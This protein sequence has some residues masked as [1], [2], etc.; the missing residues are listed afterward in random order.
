MSQPLPAESPKQELEGTP[1]LVPL[2][3]LLLLA[4]GFALAFLECNVPIEAERNVA[5]LRQTLEVR[6]RRSR[7]L[8][9]NEPEEDLFGRI[10][11]Q[12]PPMATGEALFVLGFEQSIPSQVEYPPALTRLN[13]ARE[14]FRE[15]LFPLVLVLPRYA[16]DQ[17]S[18]EAPDFWAWRSGVFEA[19]I[20]QARLA[21]LL[22]DVARSDF[23]VYDSLSEPR[24]GDH[25]EALQGLL[26]ELETQGKKSER[27]RVALHRR[28][29]VILTSMLRWP[30]ARGHAE[31]VLKLAK[32]IGDEKGAATAYHLLGWIAQSTG[33]YEEASDWYQKVLQ[34]AERHGD[35]AGVAFTF[36]L[37][38]TVAQFREA[39]EEARESFLKAL[40]IFEELGRPAEVAQSYSQLGM[41]AMTLGAHMEAREW[42]LKAIQLEDKLGDRTVIASICLG[43]GAVATVQGI[44]EEAVKWGRKA[45]TIFEELG[46]RTGMAQAFSQ[47]GAAEELRGSFDEALE[48]HGKALRISEALGDR[49]AIASSASQ[50]GVLLTERGSPGEAVLWNLR[51]LA[52][53]LEHELPEIGIDLHWL[54]HQRETLGEKR[55]RELLA[56]HVGEDGVKQVIDLIDKFPND[57]K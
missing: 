5:E 25:L 19:R 36:G 42:F 32:N 13:R 41:L 3:R 24:K 52:V 12:S 14:R 50:I 8:R 40:Q 37:L 29:A 43:L 18:R 20:K 49:A 54:S 51:S 7:L 10:R 2:L 21:R 35:Q 9:L 33:S 55:F 34:I 31:K 22:T 47:L 15:L 38:G 39:F 16:L 4:E 6:G 26:A 44:Y 28:I 53:R 48:W 45:L 57:S 56:E 30:E 11:S 27:E 23:S 17:L 46:N 1:E